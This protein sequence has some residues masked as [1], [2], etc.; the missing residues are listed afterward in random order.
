MDEIKPYQSQGFWNTSQGLQSVLHG[1]GGSS[2]IFIYKNTVH[3]RKA[4]WIKTIPFYMA[5][6][7]A[8]RSRNTHTHILSSV[9]NLATP[10]SGDYL[11]T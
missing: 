1:S 7:S 5:R 6:E 9:G 8:L 2:G 3:G 10:E 11:G 4:G